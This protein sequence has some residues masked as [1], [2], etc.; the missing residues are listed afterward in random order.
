MQSGGLNFNISTRKI[1]DDMRAK[2]KVIDGGQPLQYITDNLK[3]SDRCSTGPVTDSVGVVCNQ[4][5]VGGNN[6]DVSNELI[7]QLTNNNELIVQ[8]DI[9][10]IYTNIYTQSKFVGN[11]ELIHSLNETLTLDSTRVDKSANMPG[12]EIDRMHILPENPQVTEHINYPM[13]STLE[14]KNMCKNLK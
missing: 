13:N 6:I 5:F 7:P 1:Y 10:G 11:D 2:Q 12:L 4:M 9:N 3:P 8:K 14:I